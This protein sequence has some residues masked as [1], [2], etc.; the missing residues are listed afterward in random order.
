MSSNQDTRPLEPGLGK[1]LIDLARASIRH[2]LETGRPLPIDLSGLPPPLAAQR[3]TFVTLKKGGELRGCIGCL[4]AVKPLAVDVADNAF[5][6]A[7]RDPRFPPVTADEIDGLDIHISLLTPPEPMSFVSEADLIA[8]LRPGIDGL[9]LQEG[10]RR[11]TFL[12]TVWEI[13]PTPKAFLRQLKL[14]SG[15]PEDYWS[16]TLRIFRYRAES[17]DQ[18]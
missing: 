18:S 8:Q 16:D 15:L 17:I 10:L 3:A 9:I 1:Y 5:S 6:A 4:E 2:G 13:L 12:P 11:G 7:F 14:K